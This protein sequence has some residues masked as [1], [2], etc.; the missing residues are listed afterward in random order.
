MDLAPEPIDEATEHTTMRLPVS[1][2][3]KLR[4]VSQANRRSLTDE[5]IVRLQ[6]TLSSEVE[7]TK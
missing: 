5:V 7:P 3:R 1:L 4:D 6:S 2:K